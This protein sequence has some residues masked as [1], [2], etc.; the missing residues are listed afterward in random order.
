M[1]RLLTTVTLL[2]SVAVLPGWTCEPITLD[3][4]FDMWCG[5]KL[6][7]WQLEQGEIRRVATWH[8]S[9]YGVELDS[10]PVI[11]SQ[12]SDVT[13]SQAQCFDFELQADHDDGVSLTLELD[14]LDDGQVDARQPL[15]SDDWRPVHY[16]MTPPSWYE[17]V[18]FT[19]RK[20]GPGRAVLTQIKVTAGDDC[21]GPP[22]EL[23]DRPTGAECENNGQCK[24]GLCLA[25]MQWRPDVEG[26]EIH[27]CSAC[28]SDLDCQAEQICGL[29]ASVAYWLYRDCG[30]PARHQLG[31][32]CMA[33]G[34][35]ATG[36]CCEGTCSECCTS[37]DCQAGGTCEVRDWHTLG[38]DYEYQILPRQCSPGTGAALAGDPCLRDDDCDSNSCLGDGEFRQC[39]LDGRR[40][41]VDEDCPLWN[42][43]LA[44]GVY[45]GRCQ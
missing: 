44:L 22:I 12:L 42:A 29:E 43:C 27:A 31:E 37:G 28:R 9:D 6:C 1:N 16:S 26:G 34:E 23:D 3:P 38:D 24:Q 45:G 32:R 2:A 36:T 14:F 35:C 21:S 4:G 39:F 11:I 18:R 41:Q 40:C 25:V 7:A 33:D 5:D 8:R 20:D 30:E 13:S 10:D 17:S 19:I 15:A